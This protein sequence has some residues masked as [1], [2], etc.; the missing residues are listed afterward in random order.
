MEYLTID[1]IKKHSRV[2]CDCE[3]DVIDLYGTSAEDSVLD[4]LGCTLDELKAAHGGEVPAKVIHATLLLTDNFYQHRSP[5]EQ[6]TLSTV[7]YGFDMMLKPY[8]IL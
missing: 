1:Y 7:P 2:C 3:D 6:V 5:T 8:M 4:L